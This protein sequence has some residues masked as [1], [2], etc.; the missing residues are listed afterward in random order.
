M[1]CGHTGK[2]DFSFHYLNLVRGPEL[3]VNTCGVGYD[4]HWVGNQ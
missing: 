1:S 2:G 3:L 4:S